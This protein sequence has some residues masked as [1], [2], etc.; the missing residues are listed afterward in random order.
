MTDPIPPFNIGMIGTGWP[1]T[2]LLTLERLCTGI[3]Y[4]Q[5]VIQ[6]VGSLPEGFPKKQILIFTTD[7]DQPY[8]DVVSF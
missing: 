5:G 1:P 3:G 7:K 4:L 6:T 2:I 8:M